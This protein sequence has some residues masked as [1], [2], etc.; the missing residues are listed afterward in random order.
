MSAVFQPLSA[1][2]LSKPAGQVAIQLEG[3]TALTPFGHATA[4]FKQSST[5]SEIRTPEDPSRPVIATDFSELMGSVEI[6]FSNLNEL[7][8]AL[9]FAANVKPYVQAAVPERTQPFA[10]VSA[11]QWLELRE[12]DGPT[13][14][15]LL[16][17]VVTSVKVG[18]EVIAP[19][20]YRHDSKS[21]MVQITLWPEGA[22]PTELVEV[23]FSAPAV[24]VI[25]GLN[26][27]EL[28]QRIVIR[29]RLVLRQNN[30]RGINRKVVVPKIAFGGEGSEIQLIQ[31]GTDV[32]KIRVTGTIEADYTQPPG[33]EFGYV[34]DLPA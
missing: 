8:L 7:G 18:G 33:R 25:A 9:G 11:L 12:N 31:D 16:N 4:V 5:K 30:I 29:G 34:V 10:G 17:T 24:T 23:T 21:G 15:G 22:D 32:V 27:A 20:T 2:G 3:S 14:Q 26:A 19:A 1:L 13:A 6:E 28:L